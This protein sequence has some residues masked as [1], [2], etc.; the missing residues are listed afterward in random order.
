MRKYSHIFLS[1]RQA[2]PIFDPVTNTQNLLHEPTDNELLQLLHTAPEEAVEKIF[3]RYYGVICQ[4]VYRVIPQAETAED[5]A[6]EVFF[7][8]WRRRLNLQIG[9]SLPAYLH[10]AAVNKA[11]NHVRDRKM[12]WTDDAELPALPDLQPGAQSRLEAGELQTL[13]DEHIERLPE[14]CRLV[15]VL[16]RFESL[17]HAEIAEQLNISTKTVEN[18][19]TKALRYLRQAL[20]PYLG[21]LPF[22]FMTG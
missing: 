3:R 10:R 9:T 12:K 20:G 8:L 2:I 18:Q 4:A 19:I 16:S 7:E 13:I 11:L 5:I 15:F 14:K 1:E 22:I 21:L 17:S 6:Q